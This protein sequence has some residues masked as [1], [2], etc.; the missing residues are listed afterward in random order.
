MWQGDPP[1]PAQV[2][3]SKDKERAED[4]G[5]SEAG[6]DRMLKPT[7]PKRKVEKLVLPIEVPLYPSRSPSGTSGGNPGTGG[8]RTRTATPDEEEGQSKKRPRAT[9]AVPPKKSSQVST[10][11]GRIGTSVSK[12]PKKVTGVSLGQHEFNEFAEVT[13]DL[14]PRVVDKASRS[15]VLSTLSSTDGEFLG[16]Q[17]LQGVFSGGYLRSA[18]GVE[19]V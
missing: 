15:R 10:T 5:M 2:E 3:T 16:L 13:K 11:S 18:V 12:T 4:V 14:V 9:G 19:E 8:K 1:V 7:K 17:L 6:Q